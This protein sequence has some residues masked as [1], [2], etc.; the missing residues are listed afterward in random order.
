MIPLFRQVTRQL[1]VIEARLETALGRGE[2][3]EGN[4]A[5]EGRQ[6][7]VGGK[8]RIGK[9]GGEGEESVRREGEGEARGK[10]EGEGKGVGE[11]DVTEIASL[12]RME[13]ERVKEKAN[14]GDAEKVERIG[15]V[16]EGAKGID[17]LRLRF[18]S[19]KLEADSE[20]KV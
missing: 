5:E 11:I 3:E 14:E 7:K 4:K 1:E 15:R 19:D 16:G 8:I 2:E 13:K 12:R 10:D 9:E 6:E 20:W 18:V 17:N